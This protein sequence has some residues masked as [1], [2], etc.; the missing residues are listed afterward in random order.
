MRRL[1]W[2][3]CVTLLCAVPAC[4][5]NSGEEPGSSTGGK[6]AGA[7]GG[8]STG[9]SSAGGSATGGRD[10]SGGDASGSGG[11]DN[12]SGGGS[13]GGTTG[14]GGVNPIDEL[15]TW[16]FSCYSGRLN[17]NC[18]I[19][20]DPKCVFCLYA[21]P[22][23]RDAYNATHEGS[24]ACGTPNPANCSASCLTT[25]SGCPAACAQQ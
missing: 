18:P 3:F 17:A 24:D 9:G 21:T 12:N 10:G 13:D 1:E 22:E 23:E 14:S 15:P 5:S 11:R 7:G 19:C 8:S 25:V 6:S 20:V 2:M 16:V 4:G